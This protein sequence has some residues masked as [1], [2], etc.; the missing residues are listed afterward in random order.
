MVVVVATIAAVEVE[1]VEEKSS[2]GVSVV[3]SFV[4]T[5]VDC[6]VMD[7]DDEGRSEPLGDE[8]GEEASR[9]D[10]ALTSSCPCS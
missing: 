8:R 9:G 4:I 7:G 6:L 10:D 1:V 3:L 2:C 5:R